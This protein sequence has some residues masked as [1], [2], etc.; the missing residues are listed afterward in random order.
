MVI[1]VAIMFVRIGFTAFQWQPTLFLSVAVE[2]SVATNRGNQLSLLVAI[3]S[4]L[5]TTIFL[6][7]NHLPINNS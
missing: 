6:F 1:L 3:K 4:M 5:A 2:T 7:L